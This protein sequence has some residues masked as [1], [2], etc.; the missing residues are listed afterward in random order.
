VV[1]V[2]GPL[3]AGLFLAPLLLSFLSPAVSGEEDW[4]EFPPPPPE[5]LPEP[6]DVGGFLERALSNLP[7]I[8]PPLPTPEE[9]EKLSREMM[10]NLRKL[11]EN[12]R[13]RA[14][15]EE[16]FPENS[17]DF[18]AV[19]EMTGGSEAPLWPYLLPL[20]VTACLGL[21]AMWWRIRRRG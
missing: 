21:G 10:E 11:T 2:K 6:F 18:T 20:V 17:P 3:L 13:S 4:G 1:R 19:G 14:P 12:I 15:P 8:P 7:E 5:N 9:V 16:N